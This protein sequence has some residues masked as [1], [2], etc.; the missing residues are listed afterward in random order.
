MKIT[1]LGAGIGGLTTAIALE[2]K[3]FEVE[4]FESFPK[5]RLLK[6]FNVSASDGFVNNVT[7]IQPMVVTT[8][9]ITN[10]Q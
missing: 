9:P 10:C 1:I 6:E 7:A 2:Q 3:G 4:I 5:M 8:T